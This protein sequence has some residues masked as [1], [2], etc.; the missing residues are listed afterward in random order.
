MGTGH[1]PDLGSLLLSGLGVL[2]RLLRLVHACGGLGEEKRGK[3]Q[4]VSGEEQ[5]ALFKTF[6]VWFAFA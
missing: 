3:G 4:K 6:L 5:R 1:L 2:E